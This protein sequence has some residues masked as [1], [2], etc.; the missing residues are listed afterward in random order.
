MIVILASYFLAGTFFILLLI[1]LALDEDLAQLLKLQILIL[2]IYLIYYRGCKVCRIHK[3]LVFLVS[4][5][6]LHKNQSWW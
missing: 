4:I 1:V 6:I 2:E 5:S 3:A